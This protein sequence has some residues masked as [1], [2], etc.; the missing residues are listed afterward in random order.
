V[1]LVSK[2]TCQILQPSF[3]FTTL[4]RILP[5]FQPGCQSCTTL[6]DHSETFVIHK[7]GSV[8]TFSPQPY[9]GRGWCPCISIFTTWTLINRPQNSVAARTSLI[10]P[11]EARPFFLIYLPGRKFNIDISHLMKRARARGRV[12]SYGF[13]GLGVWKLG[14]FPGFWFLQDGRLLGVR[15]L[16]S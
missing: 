11:S 1:H 9:R 14:V 7:G 8:L 12:R 16:F 6:K 10:Y 3:P 4:R 13:W 5:V 2:N 15:D